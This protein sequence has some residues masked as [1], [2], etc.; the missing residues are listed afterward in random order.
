VNSSQ[1]GLHDNAVLHRQVQCIDLH[2]S[3]MGL[4]NM[5]EF[6]GLASHAANV[7]DT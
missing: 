4:N 7:V 3:S 1:R 6:I 2:P 5:A